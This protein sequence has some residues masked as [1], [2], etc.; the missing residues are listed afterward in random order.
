[1]AAERMTRRRGG[2][3]A[4]GVLAAVAVLVLAVAPG[5][6]A[7]GELTAEEILDE[8]EGT[9]FVGSGRATVELVTVN[10]RGQERSN[11]LVFYRKETAHGA[12]QLLEYLAPADVA[13]TKFLTVDDESGETLMWLYLP[14]LGRERRIAGSAA[15][16]SFMGT[17]FTFEEIGS[18]GTFSKDYDAERL[19]DEVYQGVDSYVL[20]LVPREAG[21][22]YS[23]VT[24]WVAKESFVPL[25]VEFYNRQ[26]SLEKVLINE[27]LRQTAQGRWQPHLI[28]MRNE[29]TGSRTV[30][31]VLETSDEP[32]PDEYFTLRYL[33]R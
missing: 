3:L 33:R 24:L 32:V 6:R 15:Q 23:A 22:K 19:A 21:G 30:I 27:D 25:R 4:A 31:R 26:G 2:L 5:V 8:L 13:G 12:N 7:A 11:R 9:A 28:T 29:S 20:R 16:D 1:M 14:A 18:L 17:D 10:A